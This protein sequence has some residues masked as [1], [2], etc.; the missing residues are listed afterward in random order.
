MNLGD[1]T[2]CGL[3]APAHR[4]EQLLEVGRGQLDLLR[5]EFGLYN[6]AERVVILEEPISSFSRSFMAASNS[7]PSRS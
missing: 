6:L 3:Y 2:R 1:N 5:L 4:L 7:R